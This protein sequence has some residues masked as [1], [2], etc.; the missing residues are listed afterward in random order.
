MDSIVNEGITVVYGSVT[1]LNRL[2]LKNLS[3]FLGLFRRYHVNQLNRDY[4]ENKITK[5]R[6]RQKGTL[7]KQLFF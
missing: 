6:G 4:R 2:A 3:I 5:K 7:N 1:S